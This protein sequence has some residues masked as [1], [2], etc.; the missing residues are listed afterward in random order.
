M[1]SDLKI[2]KKDRLP[3]PWW[4]DVDA[5]RKRKSVSFTPGL[6]CLVGPNGSG[7][8]TI[9]RTL[10]RML[11]CEQSG[12]QVVTEGSIRELMSLGLGGGSNGVLD[13]AELVHDQ[14]PVGYVDPS[15]LPGLIGGGAGFDDDFIELG[16][17]SLGTRKLSSGQQG[18]HRLNSVLS[19]PPTA[20]KWK[21]DK[22]RVNDTWGRVCEYAETVVGP[23]KAAPKA[24]GKYP[25]CTLL[26][27]EP[28]RSLDIKN[29]IQF[30]KSVDTIL[31][32]GHQIII[33]THSTLALS[34]K[35]TWI[36]LEPKYV[37]QCRKLMEQPGSAAE[38]PGA[39]AETPA[40]APKKP[41]KQ[42]KR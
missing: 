2:I 17:Q 25:P 3:C 20:V 4:N 22:D 23:N 41:P 10:A 16:L 32:G 26:F 33:A 31:T 18:L 40:A 36:E 8:S 35:A 30:W 28:E 7:K 1:L 38:P 24:G 5:L 34:R 9:L 6:N 12:R 21:I 39:A 13:G 11:H 42:Q 15:M 29:Q 19:D 14:G 37:E 27:D